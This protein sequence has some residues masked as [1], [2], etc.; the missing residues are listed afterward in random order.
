M[1]AEL[2]AVVVTSLSG[3]ALVVE[4]V[5]CSLLLVAAAATIVAAGTTVVSDEVF[6]CR[7]DV[8]DHLR[9]VVMGCLAVIGHLVLPW[10]ACGTAES[11]WASGLAPPAKTDQERTTREPTAVPI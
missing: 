9:V 3:E 7:R 5:W 4:G 6:P 1:F 8:V 10:C 11:H 2:R